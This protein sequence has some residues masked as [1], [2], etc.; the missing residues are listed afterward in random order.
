MDSKNLAILAAVAVAAAYMLGRW[1]LDSAATDTTPPTTDTTT[2]TTDV[3][4]MITAPIKS[5]LGLWRPPAEY[6]QL[7]AEA[8]FRYSIPPDLLARLLYQECHWRQD[9][10]SGA[11]RSSVG[12]MGIAQFMPATAQEMGIDPLNPA[13]AIDGA[14]RYLRS[15]YRLFGNWTQAL[16]AYNW[17]QGNVQRKGL[18]NAPA[19]TVAYYTNILGDVNAANGTAYA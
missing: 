12:A 19:E 14:G 13:Q 11:K 10:I 9:I 4:D 17:G 6:A 16:A 15:L 8:E 18:A 7:I 2:S 3:L 1:M 5:A